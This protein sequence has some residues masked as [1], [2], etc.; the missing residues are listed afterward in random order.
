MRL[1]ALEQHLV[2]RKRRQHGKGSAGEC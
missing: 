1:D 2:N